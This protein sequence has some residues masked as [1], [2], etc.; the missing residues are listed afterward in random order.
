MPK[1][2]TE[3]HSRIITAAKKEFMTYGFADASMRRIAA[4]AGITVSGLYKHF[5]DKEAMFASL[6]EPVISDFF[7]N[8]QARETEYFENAA[9]IDPDE[10]MSQ[11]RDT[12]D[13]M[14]YI[15]DHLDVFQLVLTK[16]QGTRY[17]TFLHDLAVKEEGSTMEY[18]RRLRERGI[19]MNDFRDAEFHLLVTTYFRAVAEAVIHGFTREEALHYAETIGR[20]FRPGMRE[21]FGI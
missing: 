13:M 12:V 11:S 10:I 3:T 6:T 8:Y 1:D 21:F 18:M 5:P 17:E 4:D 7:S 19:P 16:S 2:K 9:T 14:A 15:Y 20:V